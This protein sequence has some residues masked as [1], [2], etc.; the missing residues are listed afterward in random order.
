M[1]IVQSVRISGVLSN[2]AVIDSGVAQ[3][4]LIG[5]TFFNIC[6][7]D[8][9]KI[10][11]NRLKYAD[12]NVIY[13]NCKKEEIELTILDM[14]EDLKRMAEHF[15][16]NGLKLNF[17]KTNFMIFRN[18]DLVDVPSEISLDKDTKIFRTSNLMFLGIQLDERLNCKE[19]FERL[20]EK[21]TQ[22]SRAL[23]II[24]HHLPRDMLLQFFHA[25]IMSHL[26]YFSFLYVK[27]NQM[28][29]TRLQRIQNRCIK[30]IFNLDPQHSTTDL[31]KSF[32][33][34]TLPVIGIIYSSLITEHK[35]IN[36]T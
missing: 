18:N 13:K 10:S 17:S 2:E 12:D 4:S 22:S 28:E 34:N 5:P 26:Q 29:I 33:V 19:Q 9:P 11:S 24:K 32:A 6:Q 23:S 7:F 20:V 1:P 31:F 25:H 30:L 8:S 14:I 27:L 16:Q 3:G 35:K 36:L 21:L 15:H